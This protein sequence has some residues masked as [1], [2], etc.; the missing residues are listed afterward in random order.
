VN[1]AALAGASLSGSSGRLRGEPG[2]LQRGSFSGTVRDAWA[3]SGA[4]GWS[5]VGCLSVRDERV[6]I[7]ADEAS[8]QAL[9]EAFNQAFHL[10]QGAGGTK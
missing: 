3:C 9:N 1:L 5:K 7:R 8:N 4:R 6:T 2:R 10:P